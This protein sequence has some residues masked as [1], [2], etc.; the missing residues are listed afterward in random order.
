MSGLCS[1]QAPSAKNR[2]GCLRIFELCP[3]LKK[4]KEKEK[5]MFI[6]EDTLIFQETDWAIDMQTVKVCMLWK[7]F[8][9]SCING[10]FLSLC[11][12]PLV[13]IFQA[14]NACPL[15]FP[16]TD[17]FNIIAYLSLVKLF[18]CKLLFLELYSCFTM[19]FPKFFK[20]WLVLGLINNIKV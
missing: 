2:L 10:A 12:V 19:S 13:S 18:F 6:H 9:V 4:R 15:C 8:A 7:D 3:N 16:A 5:K 14:E 17:I 20:M 11:S 1:Q